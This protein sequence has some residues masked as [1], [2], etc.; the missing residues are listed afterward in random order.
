MVTILMIFLRINFTNFVQLVFQK[1][2]RPIIFLSCGPTE[3]PQETEGPP[4]LLNRLRHC[5]FLLS[6]QT[7]NRNFVF[8]C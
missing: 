7:F 8:F 4:C 2:S 5:M 3:D 1:H 6:M